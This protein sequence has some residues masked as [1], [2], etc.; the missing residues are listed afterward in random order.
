VFPGL[1]GKRVL[2]ADDERHIVRLIQVNL[3]RQGYE[4]TTVSDGREA[5]AQLEAAD[6]DLAIL[7]LMMPYM[8]GYELLTWI[9]THE[10]TA[11][12]KVGLLL[13][14]DPENYE[15]IRQAEHRA[16]WYWKKGDFVR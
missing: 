4:V 14:G 3:E 6:F 10:R 1:T 11:G 5:L 8:D 9:R 2:V 15:A 16:D 13:A 12:I 7:D